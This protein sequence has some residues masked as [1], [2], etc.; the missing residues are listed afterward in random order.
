MNAGYYIH[1]SA[2]GYLTRGLAWPG[3]DAQSPM[4]SGAI[5]H[6][7]QSY[8]EQKF[9]Q[10]LKAN[11]AGRRQQVA[12]M[13]RKY[14]QMLFDPSGDASVNEFRSAL[15]QAINKKLGKKFDQAAGSVDIENLAVAAFNGANG[16]P[17][18]AELKSA[19]NG[20]LKQISNKEKITEGRLKKIAQEI[21]RRIDAIAKN[22]ESL[23]AL[24]ADFEKTSTDFNK[25]RQEIERLAS[26]LVTGAKNF[27]TFPMGN[28]ITL[29]NLKTMINL[30]GDSKTL[31]AANQ[32]GDIGEWLAPMMKYAL[33]EDLSVAMNEIKEQTTGK[34]VEYLKGEMMSFNLGGTIVDMVINAEGKIVRDSSARTK[35]Q[36]SLALT[37]E[38]QNAGCKIIHRTN[39]TD[40]FFYINDAQGMRE[41]ISVKNYSSLSGITL[42]SNTPLNF[43]L[44]QIG[45]NSLGHLHNILSYHHQD[46]GLILSYRTAANAQIMKLILCFALV[47]YSD[48]NRPSLFMVISNRRVYLFDMDS[49][50][51]ELVSAS[52]WSNDRYAIHYDGG[53][54]AD[55]TFNPGWNLESSVNQPVY[56][57]TPQERVNAAIRNFD[58]Q[59]IHATL[60][61]HLSA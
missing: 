55:I 34:L 2:I 6:Q 51:A 50:I 4:E 20:T 7:V 21:Q 27:I 13:E 58:A 23:K 10:K 54:G 30:I 49:L 28:T 5:E 47:G 44:S 35:D 14:Q 31:L 52:L 40:A 3:E 9:G 48:Q 39:K 56:A 53:I 61:I 8:I 33:M 15:A 45:N 17:Y 38:E 24:Q 59:K 22:H 12:D 43:I 18:E 42:V 16:K 1:R 19:L 60:S 57:P 26:G 37:I 41:D 36:A 11:L 29:E 32:A 25:F 46:D